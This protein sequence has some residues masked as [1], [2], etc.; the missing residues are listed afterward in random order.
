MSGDRLTR[1]GFIGGALAVGAGATLSHAGTERS[2]AKSG[3]IPADSRSAEGGGAAARE[4]VDLADPNLGGIG[5]LLT[6]LAPEVQLPHG[7][8]VVAPAGPPGVTDAWLATPVRGF[9]VGACVLMAGISAGPD[10]L[11]Q[12]ECDHDFDTV[13]PSHARYFLQSSGIEVEYTAGAKTALFRFRRNQTGPWVMTVRAAEKAAFEQS[14]AAAIRAVVSQQGV[15]SYLFFE[16]NAEPERVSLSPHGAAAVLNLPT[17]SLAIDARLGISYIDV[18]QAERNLRAEVPQ[19][20]F[21]AAVL[22]ARGVWNEALGH[23]QVRGGTADQRTIFYTAL[24]RSLQ[25]MKDI[26]EDGQYRG[27]FDRKVHAA[28]TRRFFTEDNLW[29]TYRCRHPLATILEPDLNQQAIDSFVRMYEESGWFPQFPFMAGDLHFMNGNHAAAMVLDSWAKGQRNFDVQTAYE[30]L[31]KV[32]LEATVLPDTRGPATALDRFYAEHGYFPALR[33]GEPE[34]VSGVNREMRRQA[35]SVTLDAAY[36]DWCL[37]ELARSLGKTND[38]VMFGRRSQNYRKVWN[39][40][41]GWMAPLDASGEWIADYDPK[42]GGGQGGRDYTSECNGWVNAFGVQHDV[43]GLIGLMGGRERF[44][45][46]LDALFS[47]GYD[48]RLKFEFLSQ[49]PDSTGLIGQYPQGN[50]PAFHIPYLYCYAGAPWKTQRRVRQILDTWYAAQPLGL[51]GDDDNGAMTSWYVL[52]AMGLYPVCPGR[53]VYVLGSP[54]FEEVRVDVG[55][56]RHFHVI[57]R[58]ASRQNK[59]VQNARLDGASWEYAWISHESVMSGS[60]LELEMGPQPNTEWA[61]REDAVPPG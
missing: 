48:G 28:G 60:T 23:I 12:S 2:T 49:F 24:Y 44:I 27:P 43:A 14:G 20:E 4:L 9:A 33:K 32:A 54:I 59:Y 17:A 55:R 11:I 38:A 39:Q 10:G 41:T 21:G 1:R 29:D 58:G 57:A 13:R 25:Y 53:P 7:M 5:H 31:R 15:E 46:R 61:S 47:E 37:G 56:G 45:G 26:T 22:R 40:Q 51:P 42:W 18:P 6:S 36:D 35:V 50:E 52:G 16:L 19:W 34:T 30:G 3:A 8:C